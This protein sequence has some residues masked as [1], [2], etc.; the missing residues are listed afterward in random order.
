MTCHTPHSGLLLLG[1]SGEAYNYKSCWITASFVLII[2]NHHS[3][4]PLFFSAHLLTSISYLP[5]LQR[6]LY[7]SITRFR[8]LPQPVREKTLVILMKFVTLKKC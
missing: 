3:T 2:V 8:A 7:V 4:E 5:A 6:F 1:Q